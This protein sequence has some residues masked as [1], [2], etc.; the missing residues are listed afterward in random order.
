MKV[1]Q[2]YPQIQEAAT[3]AAAQ[4]AW[5]SIKGNICNISF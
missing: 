4:L 2:V 3:A 5:L 1:M